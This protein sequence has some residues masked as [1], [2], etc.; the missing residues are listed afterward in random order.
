MANS[1][2][3]L[4][5][6]YSSAVWGCL[7]PPTKVDGCACHCCLCNLS[8]GSLPYVSIAEG[9]PDLLQMKGHQRG[10]FLTKCNNYQIWL[11]N[12]LTHLNL[13]S[14]KLPGECHSST[15]TMCKM[16]GRRHHNC[17]LRHNLRRHSVQ[18]E[19]TGILLNFVRVKL[20]SFHS[21][22][23]SWAANVGWASG[24]SKGCSW[25]QI[26]S[27]IPWRVWHHYRTAP[28]WMARHPSFYRAQST[29]VRALI[30]GNVI[31]L[32]TSQSLCSCPECLF[33]LNDA[34][35][36]LLF[37]IMRYKVHEAFESRA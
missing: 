28:E 5:D 29:K 17:I 25:S 9:M 3:F 20:C 12:L 33:L 31:T 21:K 26:H 23:D 13:M 16:Y 1:Q 30:R 35:P 34:G 24:G 2:G 37:K 27:T 19:E 18:L 6:L 15:K 11:S 32:I 22:A 14:A 4:R 7:C 36:K 8:S 10:H